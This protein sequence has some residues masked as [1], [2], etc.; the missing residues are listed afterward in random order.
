[1]GPGLAVAQRRQ[2]SAAQR[3]GQ[4]PLTA[5]PA[6][7]GGRAAW[8]GGSARAGGHGSACAAAAGAEHRDAA[9]GAA[10]LPC[11]DAGN[12]LVRASAAA[13]AAQWDGGQPDF[14]PRISA[15][16]E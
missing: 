14:E 5:A 8:L 7:S 2:L 10:V 3:S 15:V 16:G 6:H 13:A 12:G 9:V 4:R 1:M 11:G